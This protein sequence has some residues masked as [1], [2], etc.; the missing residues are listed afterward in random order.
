[1]RWRSCYLTCR[2]LARM[3]LRIVVRRSLCT[4]VGTNPTD[5]RSLPTRHSHLVQ[6]SQSRNLDCRCEY[7]DSMVLR[8]LR[9][10]KRNLCNS[11]TKRQMRSLKQFGTPVAL[12][13]I[14]NEQTHGMR[15][16]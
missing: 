11:F 7:G 9:P 5:E 2:S 4:F 1:M 16:R 6:T 8:S 3:P 15:I 14:R 12:T 13:A 10:A